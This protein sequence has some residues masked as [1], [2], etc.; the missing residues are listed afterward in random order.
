MKMDQQRVGTVDVFVPGCPLVDKEAEEFSALLAKR[1]QSS[2]P[3]IVLAMHDVPYMDSV[4]IEGLLDA[5]DALASQASSLKLAGVTA[6]CR[7]VLEMTGVA[8]RLSFF[9]EIQDAVKSF[10]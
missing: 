4:A 8:R 3:R 10:L 2:N 6:T 5:T 9:K 1:V 7:E